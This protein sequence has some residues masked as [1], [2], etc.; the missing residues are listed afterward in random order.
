MGRLPAPSRVAQTPPPVLGAENSIM[1]YFYRKGH[2]GS[3]GPRPTESPQQP[4]MGSSA[5]TISDP[6]NSV[7]HCLCFTTCSESFLGEAESQLS[8]GVHSCPRSLGTVFASR[9]SN[10]RILFVAQDN[11]SRPFVC[12]GTP[13]EHTAQ[14]IACCLISS[15]VALSFRLV[16]I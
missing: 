2:L 9:S 15:L 11:K 3:P 12:E 14:D 16:D 6:E 1:R 7:V 8:S 5:G 13:V 4:R 10:P